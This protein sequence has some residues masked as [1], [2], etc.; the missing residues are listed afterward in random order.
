MGSA[1]FWVTRFR[2]DALRPPQTVEVI[3]SGDYWR[4]LRRHADLIVV[5]APA[6]DRSAAAVTV[7]PLM[8]ETILVVAADQPDVAAP[9]RLRDAITDAGGRCAGLFLNRVDLP[10]A[11]GFLRAAV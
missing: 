4:A 6:F 10:P 8:D 7:A 1:P 2:A 11:P 3:A 9:A 5:D